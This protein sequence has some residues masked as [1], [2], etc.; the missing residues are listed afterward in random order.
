MLKDLENKF[1]ESIKELKEMFQKIEKD[2]ENIKLEVQKIFTKIRTVINEREDEILLEI[3]NVFNDKFISEEIIK[4]G[5]KL[6]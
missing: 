6:P 3:D 2:K 4:K 1:G 5:E